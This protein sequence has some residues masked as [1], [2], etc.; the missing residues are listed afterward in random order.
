MTLPVPS[1]NTY[2]VGEKLTAALMNKNV[3]DAVTFLAA[4]P[5]FVGVATTGQSIP[6]NSGTPV[7]IN[8]TTVDTYGGHSN[9]TNNSRYTA[10]VAG[11]YRIFGQAGWLTNGNGVRVSA[12][13]LNGVVTFAQTK[14]AAVSGDTM[15]VQA[16][17]PELYLNVGDYVEQYVVQTSGGS[18]TTA[19]NFTAF[20]ITWLHN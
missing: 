18:L 19:L 17:H 9:T 16:T 5:I 15:T 7:A 1:Q 10:I 4:P 8:T 11:Y 13:Y 20:A 12:I 2:T 6:N 14:V 3:R